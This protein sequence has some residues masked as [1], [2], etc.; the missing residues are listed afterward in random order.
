[1][2]TE[3]PRL[4][5]IEQIPVKR[6]TIE[7]LAEHLWTE[8]NKEDTPPTDLQTYWDELTHAITRHENPGHYTGDL[9]IAP[10]PNSPAELWRITNCTHTEKLDGTPTVIYHAESPAN[11]GVEK[12]FNPE[13]LVAASEYDDP[14]VTPNSN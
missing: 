11:P 5:D 10:K 4:N 6:P 14:F 8:I 2:S 12:T 3:H 13:D 1:M 9:V 7:K